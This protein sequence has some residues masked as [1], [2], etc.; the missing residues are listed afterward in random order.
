MTL[1]VSHL[2]KAY[3]P[4]QAVT[5]A[6]LT[7]A[8]GQAVAIMGA[9]GAGKSTLM[10]MLGGLV[11]PDGG[12]ITLDGQALHL[13]G[14]ARAIAAGI[15]FVQQEL[16]VF[17][18][19]TVAENICIGDF[20]KRAGRVDKPAMRAEAA[21]LLTALGAHLHPD[22]PVAD[23]STG[24]RQM[25]EIARATRRKPRVLIFDEPTS[26]LAAVE[27]ARLFDLI[28]TLKAQ[29]VMILYISHFV[30]E[31]FQICDRVMVMREGRS[32]ADRAITDVTK[33]DVVKL[34]LGEIGS[35]TRLVPALHQPGAPVLRVRNL[36]SPHR[37]EDA[38]F[39]LHS[40]EIVGLWGLL[41][42]GRT[43]LA[44]GL[45]GLDG[46]VSGEIAFGLDGQIAPISPHELRHHAAFVTE[47]RR[48]EGLLLPFSAADNIALPNLGD[49]SIGAGLISR[50]K[51][52]ELANRLIAQ[53]SIKVSGPS[54][55]A[56]TLSGGN[57]QKVVFA[58]WL[59]SKPRLLI[60]DEPTR[61]LDLA[62]KGD[63][64]R[65]TTDLAAAGATVLLISS[66]LEELM[67]VCHR[68][69][70]MSERRIVA[71]LPGTATESQLIDALAM[72][73]AAA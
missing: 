60:L 68:Y 18:T 51:V 55:K 28:R 52:R 56:G 53:L 7:V 59:A 29:G 35:Q 5:D 63:I 12:T 15:A 73:G 62:A 1:T 11:L 71:E 61:G 24:E 14:P 20:P 8:P 38:S 67:R 23:L 54:Q 19:M 37:I 66:E 40:G 13:N 45:L 4:V 58:K 41:G 31:I 32:V 65:L 48:G 39:T 21:A 25:I 49:V 69:L 6:S 33:A 17:P 30:A 3:G 47:D 16:S 36:A 22:T 42:S 44:R 64:L 2:R 10:N 50:A 46:G 70:V 34:M 27:K 26:S 72:Q 57:Q 43:E 9:N